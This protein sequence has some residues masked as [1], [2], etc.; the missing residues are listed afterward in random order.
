[1]FPTALQQIG[2][3]DA[4]KTPR[5]CQALLEDAKLSENTEKI[6]ELEMQLTNS[7]AMYDA[8]KRKL[9]QLQGQ[10]IQLVKDNKALAQANLKL[11]HELDASNR[12]LD[13]HG[14]TPAKPR[15]GLAKAHINLP[16]PVPATKREAPAVMVAIGRKTKMALQE[17]EVNKRA[18]SDKFMF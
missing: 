14:L 5:G 8:L 11:K 3:I 6:K 15:R 18:N 16:P 13:Q 2:P 4:L 7:V 10:K 1:M 12:L 9:V 17:A